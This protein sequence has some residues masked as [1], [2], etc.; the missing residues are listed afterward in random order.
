MR[1]FLLLGLVFSFLIFIVSPVFSQFPFA[2]EMAGAAQSEQWY[3]VNNGWIN[4]TKATYKWAARNS[5]AGDWEFMYFYRF[6]NTTPFQ[7]SYRGFIWSESLGYGTPSYTFRG[8]GTAYVVYNDSD[9]LIYKRVLLEDDVDFEQY[10]TFWKDVEYFAWETRMVAKKAY[11][12]N[13]LQFGLFI[14]PIDGTNTYAFMG[15]KDGEVI[16]GVRIDGWG[17][18][19][20]QVSS[21][22]IENN[23]AFPW[24]AVR[25]SGHN[26]SVGWILTYF[27]PPWMCLSAGK[28]GNGE[29][30]WQTFYSTPA[31]NAY[32]RLP[33]VP[34]EHR[35]S[36]IVY[37]LYG[38]QSEWYAPVQTL[39]KQLYSSVSK[40]QSFDALHYAYAQHDPS[41][42]VQEGSIG[43]RIGV[44]ALG[45]TVYNGFFL[46]D[47][48]TWSYY[49][50]VETQPFY[51]RAGDTEFPYPDMGITTD[52]G[53]TYLHVENSPVD[54]S[55]QSVS[56][57]STPVW[58]KFKNDRSN[59]GWDVQLDTWGDSDKFDM[60]ITFRNKVSQKIKNAW[61]YIRAQDQ[62]N[63]MEFLQITPG[64]TADYVI[65][66]PYRGYC[67]YLIKKIEGNASGIEFS[68]EGAKINL[69]DNQ[70]TQTYAAGVTFTIK[71]MLWAHYGR[72]TSE[73][74][75]TGY[76]TSP[77]LPDAVQ[78]F[79]YAPYKLNGQDSKLH[80]PYNVWNSSATFPIMKKTLATE[81]TLTTIA[82]GTKTFTLFLN[83]TVF[84]QVNQVSD[85]D[86]WSYDA[87][88]GNLTFSASFSGVK[89]IKIN[90]EPPPPPPTVTI[91]PASADVQLGQSVLFSSSVTGGLSPY[92]YQWYV[93]DSAV[94]GANQPTYLFAPTVSG[95]HIVQLYVNDSSGQYGWSNIAVVTASGG[96]KLNLQIYDWDNE[97]KIQGADVYLGT[98]VK[99]SDAE[100]WANWTGIYGP[101]NIKVKYYG[102]LVNETSLNVY[103]DMIVSV[104]CQLYDV[105]TVVKTSNQE[106]VVY[107]ANVTAYSLGN[108]KIGTGITGIDGKLRL[109][110]IPSGIIN[111]VASSTSG[112]I[113]TSAKTVNSDEESFLVVVNGNYGTA[114]LLWEQAGSEGGGVTRQFGNTHFEMW[115]YTTLSANYKVGSRFQLTENGKVTMMSAN[116]RASSGT[117]R[118][119][120]CIYDDNSGAPNALKGVSIVMSV[121]TAR[122]WWNFSFSSPI[123]L[124]AG[125][126]WLCLLSD[127]DVY[128]YID[129]GVTKQMAYTWTD[130]F[131]TGPTATFGT[132][133]Y[134]NIALN[135]FATYSTGTGGPADV[136]F[137]KWSDG[138]QRD[139]VALSHD[140]YT[141]IW[142]VISNSSYGV[143]NINATFSK[144][145]EIWVSSCSGTAKIANMTIIIRDPSSVIQYKWTT[146]TWN[147]LGEAYG[148]SW[149]AESNVI[150][151]IEIWLNGSSLVNAGDAISV[152]LKLKST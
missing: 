8:Q 95:M 116:I 37:P 13:Q 28:G 72:I 89:N 74:Q 56:T 27:N 150:Y 104:R 125:Y 143:K 88:T 136:K 2:G 146:T 73:D 124:T 86:S 118:V 94:S 20:I 19:S 128:F 51:M 147:N 44:I 17:L 14:G 57:D 30:Q 131:N 80:I 138:T 132:T 107:L 9:V 145:V 105:I 61:T 63:P 97:D 46:K 135:I 98:Y 59:F 96:Y 126:Y 50:D 103:S 47:T 70:V 65:N 129:S 142:T 1:R 102:Y 151:T 54:S 121:S 130:N 84:H 85:V 31:G 7:E 82:S 81:Y 141:G 10:Y 149:T 92:S 75:I 26:C 100:G 90:L 22:A 64:I 77:R 123:S 36:T 108:E 35:I 55:S 139:S 62:I 4:V 6:S 148:V 111:F 122:Q 134:D 68:S 49:P 15:Y 5:S 110:N 34:F 78:H 79:A 117:A 106:G 12:Q 58:L 24:E 67:G 45:W 91:S 83:K 48:T 52:A 43:N 39:A 16:K 127:I 71:I 21:G 42:S 99:K 109:I 113:S 40:S 144:N 69:I 120:A 137:Y 38:D 29:L 101:V 3:V 133:A 114:S 140:L 41:S 152:N 87:A 115:S 32:F 93:N 53:T 119:K 60:T 76:H 11:V 33:Y 25:S 18:G 112:A 66:D 23:K